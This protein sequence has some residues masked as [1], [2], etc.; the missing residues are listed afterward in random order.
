MAPA[1]A[2]ASFVVREDDGHDRGLKV[3]SPVST[4][5][6]VGEAEEVVALAVLPERITSVCHWSLLPAEKLLKCSRSKVARYRSRAEQVADWKAGFK[7]E[8]A[9]LER[10]RAKMGNRLPPSLVRLLC[11]VLWKAETDSTLREQMGQLKCHFE[12][13]SADARAEL[14]L[15]A[16]GA[17]SYMACAKSND[18]DDPWAPADPSRALLLARQLSQLQIYAHT[19]MNSDQQA[20]AVGLFAGKC[21]LVNHADEANAVPVYRLSKGSR[22]QMQLVATRPLAANEE[23]TISYVDPLASWLSRQTQLETQYLLPQSP[24]EVLASDAMQV[25]LLPSSATRDE[26]VQFALHRG[27]FIVGVAHDRWGESPRAATILDALRADA[28]E[29]AL[30]RGKKSLQLDHDHDDDDAHGISSRGN[31][32]DELV[33]ALRDPAVTP[34]WQTLCVAAG[35]GARSALGILAQR[36][37]HADIAK[38]N[39]EDA[40]QCANIVT[41]QLERVHTLAS[42][43][44]ATHYAA[45]AKLNNYFATD[46]TRVRECA[47]KAVESFSLV[48]GG[49]AV[50]RL[51]DQVEAKATMTFLQDLLR[52]MD[53]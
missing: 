47:Q 6:L 22:P 9:A 13:Y 1:A 17:N 36:R 25:E 3:L 51:G 33:A 16:Q 23:V 43:E 37:M 34:S 5:G 48:Y 27:R 31:T 29:S 19:I 35:L 42:P 15:L 12:S 50:P 32:F 39:F 11:R 21:R 38:G 2:T 30:E 44:L 24:R 28:A 40:L 45:L 41:P 8:C 49:T 10:W 20:L 14:M 53:A 26:P 52:V 4:G 46:E 7:Q 18:V